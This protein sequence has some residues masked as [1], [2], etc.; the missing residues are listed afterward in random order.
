MTKKHLN[1]YVFQLTP[2]GRVLE[3]AVKI[4]I[5]VF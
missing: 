3:K 4:K 2:W 5:V 1:V